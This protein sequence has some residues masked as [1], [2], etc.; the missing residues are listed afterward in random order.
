M[1]KASSF[2]TFK[3]MLT[4][5]NIKT[6]YFDKTSKKGGR[7]IDGITNDI[8]ERNAGSNFKIIQNKC[9]NATYNFSPYL[10]KLKSKGRGKK[11]RLISLPSIRDRIVLFILKEYL[12]IVFDNC[13]GRELPNS[14]VRKLKELFSIKNINELYFEKIDITDFYG[15]ISHDILFK[16]LKRRIKSVLVMRLIKKAIQN[17]T[18]NMGYK[19]KNVSEWHNRKGVPQGLA[20]SNILANIYIND[21][22]NKFIEKEKKDNEVKYYRFV[23]DILIISSKDKI[24]HLSKLLSGKL[25][26]GLA[27]NL[28]SDKSVSGCCGNGF[29]YLGYKFEGNV[30]SVRSSSVERYIRSLAG[31][32]SVYVQDS[33]NRL[34]RQPWLKKKDLKEIFITDLNESITGA[35]NEK[36]KY[37][38]LFYFIEINDMK[39]L[40][41]ID[42]LIRKF[43]KRVKDF[44][45]KP[46][47]ELKR[48]V[49]A[50]YEAKYKGDSKYIHNYN[51]YD[52]FP[53]KLNYLMKNGYLRSGKGYTKKAIENY[54]D[55]IK[56]RRLSRLDIDTGTI[57]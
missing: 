23:D 33:K 30:V 47:K 44:K 45:R 28:N 32:F 55:R 27:L 6:I 24:K 25:I 4:I 12:H 29:E 2:S 54:F 1:L 36:R 9:I 17:P 50:Y 49:K 19:R 53:K 42:V 3:K 37:G 38:W 57:S 26:R 46:P 41:Q 40:F 35:I 48:L 34:Q 15:S 5:K 43:F 31:L 52:T 20:I 13:V 22:D 21:V 56:Q 10:E 11:P 18:F 7:G 39:L 14:F 16:I 51:I 8:F